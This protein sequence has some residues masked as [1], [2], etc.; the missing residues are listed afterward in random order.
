MERMALS[1]AHYP[2]VESF[3]GRETLDV[4]A[5]PDRVE[6]YVIEVGP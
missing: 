3:L 2:P 5:A 1:L 4:L 6:S